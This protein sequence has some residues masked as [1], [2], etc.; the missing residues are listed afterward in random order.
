[1]TAPAS[2][3]SLAAE[4]RRAALILIAATLALTASAALTLFS[5]FMFY[6]DEGYILVSLRNFAEHGGLYRE[7][8]SQYG[9]LPYVFHYTLSLVGYPLTHVGG[10]L[11]TLV[12]WASTAL[13]CARLV[14]QATRQL[15]LALP[16]LCATFLILW[17]MAHEPNH[18]G[19][20]SAAL[21]ALAAFAGFR[22]AERGRVR[23]V[24]LIGGALVAALALTKINLGVFAA[25][26]VVSFLALHGAAE[27]VRRHA[28]WLFVLAGV[29]LPFALMRTLLGQPWVQTY[30]LTFAAMAISL[31]LAGSL[32]ARQ[33]GTPRFGRAEIGVASLA[34]L[35]V[36][37]VTVSVVVA[38]GTTF[39]EI[40]EGT[41]LGPL[42]H[43]AV[44]N[45]T[46]TWPQGIHVGIALGCAGALGAFALRGSPRRSAIDLTVAVLRLL[47]AS[48]FL[49]LCLEHFTV[50]PRSFLFCWS[51]PWL[52]VCL[53]PLP[54]EKPGLIAGRTWL[55]LLALGQW[56][57]A[58]PVPGSQIGWSSFLAIP[59]LAVA[60][61]G[62]VERLTA[63]LGPIRWLRAGRAAAAAALL[64]ISAA[65]CLFTARLGNV[66]WTSRPLGLPGMGLVRI[67]DATTATYRILSFNAE[68]HADML[69]TLPGM[70]SFNLWTGLPPPTL[71]N[72]T[73][74]FSLLDE[75]RQRKI[76]QALEA[77]PRAAVIVHTQH[78]AYLRERGFA[79]KGILYDY[80][81]ENFA[82]AFRIDDFEFHLRR[83][84]V[85]APFFTAELLQRA[86]GAAD[87]GTPAAALRI[88]L[89][90]PPGTVIDR[91]EIARMDDQTT[92]PAIF[93]AAR[94]RVE[95]APIN[96]AGVPLAAPVNARFPLKLEGPAL[97][98]LYFDK[99][100]APLSLRHT[101]LVLRASDGSE[102]ALARLRP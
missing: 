21:L 22:A 29:L 54:Q 41:L 45:L 17:A 44:F 69:F 79:P 84:R 9:P 46:L 7:V 18:P 32:A 23:S 86:D 14:W 96:D 52:W 99:P 26:S 10:R 89:A 3:P 35:A 25:C 43:P 100:P 47:L 73:H 58:Y 49:I 31:I 94:T 51:A 83:G 90:L 19:G 85:A 27:S 38:R 34:A 88:P 62:A 97:L 63:T 20:I 67:P 13:L 101:L 37:V 33:A 12:F 57:H 61:P 53:W 1:M 60:V 16:T 78:V 71:A 82:P 98:S 39:A 48:V 72:T 64:G 74:W 24:A 55:G 102:I 93:D 80:L 70:C 30:A 42:R 40:V 8:Y 6:D 15:T 59:L 77:H 65:I 11:I 76:I 28:V 4:N 68:A 75:A 92:P 2:A 95:F 5:T 36:G 56:L 66:Y 50:T 81:Q 87:P 91:I